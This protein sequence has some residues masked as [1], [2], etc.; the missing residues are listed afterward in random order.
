AFCW[1]I[2]IIVGK[3]LSSGNGMQA[4]AFAMVFGAAVTVPVGLAQAGAA[5]FTWHALALG[6]LV[7]ALSS[8]IPYSMQILALKRMPRKVFGLTL[9]MEPAASA[10]AGMALLGEFLTPGQ[11]IAVACVVTASFGSAYAA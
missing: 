5:L 9:S 4:V 11:W 2:Y 6:L 8:S 3:R 7:G 10:L 1:A